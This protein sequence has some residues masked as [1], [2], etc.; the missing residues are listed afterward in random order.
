MIATPARRCAVAITNSPDQDEMWQKLRSRDLN[1]FLLNYGHGVLV[2][3]NRA[4]HWPQMNCKWELIAVRYRNQHWS[5]NP[6][7]TR[8]CIYHVTFH[9]LRNGSEEKFPLCSSVIS[10]SYTH[11]GSNG[12]QVNFQRYNIRGRPDDKD[13]RKMSM[14]SDTMVFN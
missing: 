1:Q 7:K 14:F 6:R 9:Q 11:G 8:I 12:H 2:F 4:T 13:V 10:K 3:Y 5:T